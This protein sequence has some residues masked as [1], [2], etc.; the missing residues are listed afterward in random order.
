M[1]VRAVTR[2]ARSPSTSNVP[3][4]EQI[5]RK[6]LS[7]S[8]TIGS[9]SR[10]ETTLLA[11]RSESRSQFAAKPTGSASYASRRRTTSAR[12]AGSLV[13]A[14]STVS[15]NRSSSCGLSSPSSGFMVPTSRNL[16]ACRTEMPSRST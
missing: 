8:R 10:A 4:T 5:C 2:S 1:A 15:P 14:T 13:P 16:A 12:C 3:Q 6:T 7:G 11:I 9:R